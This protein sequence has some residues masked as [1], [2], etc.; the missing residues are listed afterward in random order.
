[1]KGRDNSDRLFGEIGIDTLSGVA[2]ADPLIGG[3][4]ADLLTSGIGADQFIFLSLSDDCRIQ[5]FRS[6][7]N[8]PFEDRCDQTTSTNDAFR[9]IGMPSF[10]RIAGELRSEQFGGSTVIMVTPTAMETPVSR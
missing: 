2:G 9:F 5:P 6:R 10:I 8:Q 7:S 4:G 3:S 1:M